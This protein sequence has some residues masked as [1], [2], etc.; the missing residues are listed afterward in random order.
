M[1][2]N[3]RRVIYRTVGIIT[4]A[5]TVAT[6]VPKPPVTISL[7]GILRTFSTWRTKKDAHEHKKRCTI[8]KY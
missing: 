7:L 3:L 8:N 2:H 5:K 4:E 6:M 1:K